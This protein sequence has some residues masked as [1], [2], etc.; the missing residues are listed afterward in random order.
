MK[1][2]AIVVLALLLTGCA[3]KRQEQIR[4]ADHE[5]NVWFCEQLIGKPCVNEPRK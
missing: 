4:K 1:S 2:A 3:T 5:A